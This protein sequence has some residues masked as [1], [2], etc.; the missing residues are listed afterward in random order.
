MKWR[1]SRCSLHV[2]RTG[3]AIKTRAGLVSETRHRTT[4][5]SDLIDGAYCWVFGKMTRGE[6]CAVE[7]VGMRRGEQEEGFR[8]RHGYV[9]SINPRQSSFLFG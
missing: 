5:P 3:V 2:S 7:L 9:I 1:P 6:L 4:Q 8:V